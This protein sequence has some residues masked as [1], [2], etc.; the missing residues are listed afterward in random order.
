MATSS[1]GREGDGWGSSRE[2]RLQKIRG[3]RK[4]I[5]E[6]SRTDERADRVVH[7]AWLQLLRPAVLEAW[8]ASGLTDLE[9]VTLD[10]ATTPAQV[11]AWHAAHTAIDAFLSSTSGHLD[12]DAIRLWHPLPWIG[13][14]RDEGSPADETETSAVLTALGANAAPDGEHDR[15]PATGHSATVPDPTPAMSAATRRRVAADDPDA[16]TTA[17]RDHLAAGE[18]LNRVLGPLHSAH[19]S[20]PRHPRPGRAASLRHL[21]SKS[22]LGSWLRAADMGAPTE[23]AQMVGQVAV[24]ACAAATFWLP[25]GQ[26]FDFANSEP[27][28]LEDADAILLPFPQVFLAFAEPLRLSAVRSGTQRERT[29]LDDLGIAANRCTDKPPAFDDFVGLPYD[30]DHIFDGV[31]LGAAIDVSGARVE[32]VL[33]LADSLGRLNDLFAWCVAIP[34][35]G[36]GTLGRHVIPARLTATA[37]RPLVEN[38]VAV[39]AWADWHAPDMSTRVPKGL[40]LRDTVKAM[41]DPAFTRDADRA[42]AGGVHVLN[43]RSRITDS[44]G[45]SDEPGR[46]TAPHVRRGH[47]RRQRFGPGRTEVKRV[48]IAPVLVNASKGPV[49]SARIYTIPSEPKAVSEK[50]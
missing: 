15:E 41:E 10:R 12:P 22:A 14:F 27:L 38:L 26:T 20:G 18:A 45:P 43:I 23:Q 35:P 49:G 17:W 4:Q 5:T 2:T 46:S 19:R 24:G 7:V 31:S 37:H 48:R 39:A 21:Y 16:V 33:V 29:V 32:G 11:A 36:V 34:T 47:W 3:D 44:D 30:S 8:E 50:G 13:W 42:G 9:D 28:E 1:T 25:A 6:V 40:P